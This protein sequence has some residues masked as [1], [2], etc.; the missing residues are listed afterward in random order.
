[1]I[2]KYLV[3]GGAGPL[4]KLIISM[5][6][7]QGKDVRIL[8]SELADV[9]EYKEKNIEISYGISTDKDTMKEFF[10]LD[11]PRSAVLIHADEYISL[12]DRT[13][14][15]MRRV[16]VAGTENIID[17]CIKRK[18]GR[19]VYLSSAYALNPEVQGEEMTIHFDRNKVEGEYAK[20]KAEAAAFVMEK[21][22]L[23]RLNAVLVL[24]TFI[25]GPGYAEDH[26]I[27]KIL[28]AYLKDG[29]NPIKEGGGHAFV[30]VR[31]VAS[32]MLALV[33]KGEAGSG[34]I[35]SGAYKTSDE[36]FRDVNEVKGIADPIKMRPKWVMKRSLAKFVDTYYKI[37]HKE[38]PKNVYALFQDN[39]QIMYSNRND[40]IPETVIS[41][42]DSITDSVGWVDGSVTEMPK[43]TPVRLTQEAPAEEAPVAEAPVEETPAAAEPAA[44]V[45]EA[46]VSAEPQVAENA[47]ES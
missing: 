5:L 7:E 21:I 30:D 20:T 17:M 8:M 41:F 36:F 44:A 16:N 2:T 32:A 28:R 26:D 37:T 34:Y 31:D 29:V 15:N 35:V 25:I 4:G 39:P 47:P 24:P 3:T 12:S 9:S 22:T 27:N 43:A 45:E 33:D 42:K 40:I 23:N 13:N 14:L 1:M 18:I 38:N 46:P 11:D 19:V 6:L 10:T